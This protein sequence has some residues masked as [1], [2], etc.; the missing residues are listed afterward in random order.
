MDGNDTRSH[1]HESHRSADQGR[2]RRA[3]A[4]GVS[5]SFEYGPAFGPG[6]ERGKLRAADEDRERVVELLKVAYTEG[7]L[8]KDEYDDRVADALSARTYADL[9]VL[10]S[11]LPGAQPM[12]PPAV[13][14]PMVPPPA[15]VSRI[16]GLAI[17]SLACGL[18]QFGFGPLGT[19]PA[20]VFGHMARH[21]IKQTGERG[22][23]LAVAGLL[24]GYG[25]VVV[26]IVL[27]TLAVVAIQSHPQF[28]GGQFPGGQFPGPQFPQ[29]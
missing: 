23:A 14:A 15:P 4:V 13:T 24:L 19:I 22:G 17:A 10:V 12:V 6:G 11:D 2:R 21:Q 29:P 18:A 8:S 3:A 28:P 16:N 27:L 5:P 26:G 7:R 25:A 1:V 9:D 20:I